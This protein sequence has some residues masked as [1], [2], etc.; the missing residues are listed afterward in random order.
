LFSG[1]SYVGPPLGF[2][3]SSPL[4]WLTGHPSFRFF[5][6]STFPN[7]SF[8]CFLTPHFDFGFVSPIDRTPGSRMFHHLPI[9]FSW[10]DP[11]FRSVRRG[12]TA[13]P[14]FVMGVFDLIW[15]RSFLRG[16]P[17]WVCF[18]LHP[19]V[20]PFVRANPWQGVLCSA[21]SADFVIYGRREN[22]VVLTPPPF[23]LFFCLVPTPPFLLVTAGFAE[24]VPPTRIF[25]TCRLLRAVS[26]PPRP[27]TV[28]GFSDC[29]AGF[30]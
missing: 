27:S 2:T 21:G 6:S 28:V 13:F 1:R 25:V 12:T 9:S 14:R 24:G 23:S 3:E 8:P 4:V 15:C 7:G 18:F 30:R 5:P 20:V 26:G 17:L 16:P 29:P 22:G 19:V 10:N 11:F